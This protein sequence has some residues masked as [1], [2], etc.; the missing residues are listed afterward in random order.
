MIALECV[1]CFTW[2]RIL[3]ILLLDPDFPLELDIVFSVC[4]TCIVLHCL[5]AIVV[6]EFHGAHLALGHSWKTR[7]VIFDLVTMMNMYISPSPTSTHS[8]EHIC[9]SRE[10]GIKVS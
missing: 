3:T 6:T 7:F 10:R 1:N 5:H 2:L 4:D 8:R 9:Q